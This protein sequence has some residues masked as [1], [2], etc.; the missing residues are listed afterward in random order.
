MNNGLGLGFDG[1]GGEIFIVKLEETILRLATELE[2]TVIILLG[3]IFIFFQ[4]AFLL[5]LCGLVVKI[6]I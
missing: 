6:I 1:G 2:H 5:K 3:L 4:L